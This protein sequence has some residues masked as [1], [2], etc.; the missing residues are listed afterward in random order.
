MQTLKTEIDES[1]PNGEQEKSILEIE[2]QASYENLLKYINEKHPR[3][4]EYQGKRRK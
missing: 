3:I 4:V 2:A 1:V